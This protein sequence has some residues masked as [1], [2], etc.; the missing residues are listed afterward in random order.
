MMKKL[1]LMCAAAM[2]TVSASAQKTTI[3]SNKAG[4]NWYIGANVGIGTPIAKFTNE[5]FKGA[6]KLTDVT[7]PDTV[8]RLGS[9]CFFGT[10][11]EAIII[12]DSVKVI[13]GPLSGFIGTVDEL[14]PE[15]DRVRVVVSMFGRETPVELELNQ[16]E[17]LED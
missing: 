11:I 4:D 12:P 7:I 5:L 3:T 16:A 6:G 9:G 17:K 15:K 2:L 8:V 14:E 13:D 10:N 1:I